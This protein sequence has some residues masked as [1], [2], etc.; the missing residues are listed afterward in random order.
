MSYEGVLNRVA[1]QYTMFNTSGEPVRAVVQLSLICADQNVNP[2]SL[3]SW[4]KAYNSAFGAGNS[5]V[6]A[7]QKVGSLLNIGK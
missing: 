3:G 7:G 5:L 4:Q 1:S 6:N 2:H